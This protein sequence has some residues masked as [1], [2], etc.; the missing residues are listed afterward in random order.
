MD[1]ALEQLIVD[2][3]AAGE[4]GETAADYVLAACEGAAALEQAV[5]GAA[6]ERAPSDPQLSLTEHDLGVYLASL[7]VQGFRGVGKRVDLALNPGPGLT[8]VVGRNG[9]GKS[10]FAEGLELLMTG[11]NSR[12][13]SRTKAW[14]EGW[15]NLHFDG[16]TVLEAQLQ[17]EG[18][19]GATRL[20]R[21][22]DHGA[23]LGVGGAGCEVT[24]GDGTPTSLDGLGWTA[25]LSRYRPFL[26]FNELGSMFDEQKRMYDALSAILG[27]DDVDALAETLRQARLQRDKLAKAGKAE[28]A[29]FG[30]LLDGLDDPRAET[31]RAA[32]GA[33]DLEAVEAA[34]TG[35]DEVGDLTALRALAGLTMPGEP[36][37]DE[38]LAALDTARAE[39]EAVRDTDA[40]RAASVSRL[41]STALAHHEH[42]AGTDC[43]VCGTSGA[44]GDDWR[45]HAVKEIT[46][47][48]HEAR[49][50][51]AARAAAA[52][53]RRRVGD[54]LP[55]SPPGAV[56]A[57]RTLG[58]DPAELEIAWDRW[59]DERD[60]V[61][62]PSS[63]VRLRDTVARLRRAADAL[64]VRA[65][66]ELDHR[67]DAWRPVARRL[68]EWLPT[69]RAAR[70]AEA[71][72]KD[73]KAAE[74]WVKAAA[75]DLRAERLAPIADAARANWELLRQESNISVAGFRL[76]ASGT[77]K[78]AEIDVRVDDSE[79]SAI[80]VMSQGELHAL[81]VSVFLPRAALPE[82]PFRFAVI[83]DPVQSMDPAKVD[84]LARALARAAGR[85]QVIV[86]THDERLTTATRRLGIDATVLEVTRQP[87]SVVGIRPGLDPIERYLDDAR[88][89]ELSDV[90]AAVVARV[91]PGLCRGALEAA[92]LLAVRRRR[93]ARGDAH[94]AIDAAL[95]DATKLYPRLALAL[96]DDSAKHGEVLKR[97]NNKWG[98]K[99]G[100]AVKAAN[101]G[102]HETVAIDVR[103]IERVARGVA[104]LT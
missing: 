53:A 43:P 59:R 49:A 50:V 25:A 66:V 9:S 76:T 34:V 85:R 24:T 7:G 98:P 4:L 65:Q 54:L 57:A 39:L 26:S 22:W 92:A 28:A 96:F 47:L 86:F 19:Q 82:S 93:L 2:R 94:A 101:A 18:E 91:L 45:S 102:V 38:R 73:L 90:P 37:L 89:L 10:S 55:A 71:A 69:A 23:P 11:A 99:A 83:D 80:G 46:R 64:A 72:R 51:E 60:Q 81:A 35:T 12:W 5:G 87:G 3:L 70:D 61:D 56:A 16:E 21:A 32:L 8:I 104:A 6:P 30:P 15:Q 1:A 95:G 27:L 14:S 13:A 41:L 40:G 62:D 58:L 97:V 103:E 31:V 36:E 52:A 29:A 48:D 79:A 75:T 68:A 42:H 33:A 44:L 63:T 20:R 74:D 84:G 17:V 88:A 67:E 100:D 78:R 77:Q